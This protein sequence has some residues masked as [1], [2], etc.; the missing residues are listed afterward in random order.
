[1]QRGLQKMSYGTSLAVVFFAALF[2]VAMSGCLATR[3]PLIWNAAAN[4]SSLTDME[5]RAGQSG[6][7]VGLLLGESKKNFFF[8]FVRLFLKR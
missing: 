8:F 6:A 3:A 4:A 7:G 2:A 1:M 5:F